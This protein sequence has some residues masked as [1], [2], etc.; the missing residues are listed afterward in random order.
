MNYI[1]LIIGVWLQREKGF[2]IR[3]SD[4]FSVG[5]ASPQPISQISLWGNLEPFTRALVYRG[6]I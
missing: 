5:E 3:N 1:E 2:P 4:L 6:G